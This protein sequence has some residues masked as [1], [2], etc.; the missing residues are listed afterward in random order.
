MAL[1]TVIAV[2]AG[3]LITRGGSGPAHEAGAQRARNQAPFDQA[4]AGLATARVLR[5]QD[6]AAAGITRRDVT[7]TPSG[8]LFGSTGDGGQDPGQDVLRIGGTTYTR[9]KKAGPDEKPDGEQD[10]RAPGTWTTADPGSSHTLAPV[11]SRFLPPAEL[12]VELWDAVDKLTTLPDPNDPHVPTE[13]V[14]GVPALRADT[15][16]G[17]LLVTKSKPYRVLRL[18]PYGPS[19]RL[20]GRLTALRSGAEASAMRRVTTGPLEAGD[21]QGMDLS[22]VSGS[23]ADAAYNALEAD[24][25][26]LADAVDHGIDFTLN[27]TE[28]NVSC[29]SGG[30]TVD[31]SFTGELTSDARTRLTGGTVTA[32][33]RATVT[34]DG[35]DAG[36]CTSP[37]G[38]FPLTGDT[39]S[40]SLSCSDPGAGAVFAAVREKY[41]AQ[42]EAE[43]RASGGRPVP[44]RF[45]YVASPVVD[46]AALATGEVAKLVKQVQRER[47]PGP[48]S[49]RGNATTP[50][51]AQGVAGGPVERVHV[52]SP[53]GTWA[54]ATSRSTTGDQGGRTSRTYAIP[55]ARLSD[56]VPVP[57]R[58]DN[59]DDDPRSFPNLIPGDKPDWFK[60]IPPATALARSGNYLYAVLEDGELVIGK[61]TSGHVNLARGGPVLAAGEFKTKGGEVVSLDNKSG[62]YRPYGSHAERAAVSAFN[63]NGLK[64]DGKYVAAWG[65]P[66][67]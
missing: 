51:S 35:R 12:A 61:R 15:S 58:V 62:H 63:R 17:S 33:M 28:G 13:K 40:G 10:P 26:Q 38:T 65:R 2:V 22:P 30:C 41:K 11:L 6:T 23:R 50:A 47:R 5:Y 56:P 4:L 44:Y 31:Q 55:S 36:G 29:G 14:H 16:A 49:T 32:T 42:A 27:T 9:W 57:V 53:S 25:R 24:T 48:C 43:S 54:D 59:G 18:E 52:G 21:S 66:D 34:I 19:G 1:C 20:T 45:P 46:A 64:A 60:P 8:T 3:L 7:V 39:V 37:Q 67:C